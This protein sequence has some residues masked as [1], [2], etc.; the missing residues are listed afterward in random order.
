MNP[1]E[2]QEI[3]NRVIRATEEECLPWVSKMQDM[4]YYWVDSP[5]SPIANDMYKPIADLLA[6]AP[7]DILKLIAEVKRL[8]VYEP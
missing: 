7:T 4:E 5:Y 2:L 6:N 8:R 1:K 3:E